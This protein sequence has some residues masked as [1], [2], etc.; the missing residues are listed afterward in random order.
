MRNADSCQRGADYMIIINFKNY[1]QALGERGVQLA[2]ELEKV[3]KDF[4]EVE[5]VLAVP[6]PSIASIYCAVS[7]PVYAQHIDPF[8]PG[9]TTGFVIAEAVNGAGAV[10][11]IINH[12]ERPMAKEM[13]TDAVRR[14]RNSGMATVVCASSLEDIRRVKNANS[15]FIAYEPPELIGGDVSVSEAQPDIIAEAV[16]AA[17]PTPL[18]CGA[19]INSKKDVEKALELGGEGVLVA[20]AVVTAEE[21]AKELRDLM[22]GFPNKF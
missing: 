9:Q 11:T 12:S 18:L 22:E 20:S 2:K 15:D 14:A 3:G 1:P 6:A 19:G 10:G 21:P 17:R 16:T 8:N 5:L 13:I 4:P 7:L